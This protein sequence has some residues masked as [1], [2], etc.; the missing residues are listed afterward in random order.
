MESIE[1]EDVVNAELHRSMILED[2]SQAIYIPLESVG[3]HDANHLQ[4][5]KTRFESTVEQPCCE[6]CHSM[7]EE[8]LQPAFSYSDEEIILTDE[9]RR[10]L[11]DLGEEFFSF[12]GNLDVGRLETSKARCGLCRLIFDI[13]RGPDGIL[14]YQIKAYEGDQFNPA[15]AYSEHGV[16]DHEAMR[17]RKGRRKRVNLGIV[18]QFC[19]SSANSNVDRLMIDLE[20]NFWTQKKQATTKIHRPL[21]A[22]ATASMCQYARE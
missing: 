12:W 20:V 10:E 2:R 6:L 8:C 21:I 16:S 22:F 3:Q 18:M 17:I 7:L 1:H 5:Q 14:L 13:L 11:R 9:E 15:L 4:S 19:R